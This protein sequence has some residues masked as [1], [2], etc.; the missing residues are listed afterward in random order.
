M[1]KQ[2]NHSSVIALVLIF[3]IAA[4]I[5]VLLSQDKMSLGEDNMGGEAMKSCKQVCTTPISYETKS[6]FNLI[7]VTPNSS[8]C[9]GVNGFDPY[10][11]GSIDYSWTSNG[12][13]TEQGASNYCTG[14]T[15]M[16]EVYCR[17]D[18]PRKSLNRCNLGCKDGH[19]IEPEPVCKRVCYFSNKYQ[20]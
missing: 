19:C 20:S 17:D 3:T 8:I 5:T 2:Q 9:S 6:D 1:V 11:S 10:T 4:V 7:G 14:S 16:Y 18:L 15:S 13:K 12:V